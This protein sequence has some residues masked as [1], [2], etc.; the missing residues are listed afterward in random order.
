MTENS[1]KKYKDKDPA[2]LFY[3]Q[4]WLEGTREMNSEERGVYIDLLCYQHQRGSLP[5]EM[6][7]LAKLGGE[8]EEK[9]TKIWANIKSKF[10]LVNNR[11]V[12]K[13]LDHLTGKRQSKALR[14][15]INSVFALLIRYS[16]LT[17]S[18]KSAIKSKFN[19]EDFLMY[20]DEKE[21][22]QKVTEWYTQWKE[23][24]KDTNT[25]K[26]KDTN[27]SITNEGGLGEEKGK[28]ENFK[29]SVLSNR[30]WCDEVCMKTRSKFEELPIMIDN[31]ISHCIMGGETHYTEKEFKTHFRNVCLSRIEI[32]RPKADVFSKNGTI[33][34]EERVSN[35]MESL[36]PYESQY[37]KEMLEGFLVHW[38]QKSSD[39]TLLKWEMEGVFDLPNKLHLWKE[40]E[41]KFN[42]NGHGKATREGVGEAT[43][44]FKF[45]GG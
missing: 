22:S 9:F 33:S 13:K 24:I 19:F 29:K 34:I 16:D 1:S 39:G 42:K 32:V 27:T 36:S 25:T 21:I 17:F 37:G 7:R 31:F 43:R 35:F 2:F 11:Y 23:S 44:N 15:K 40:N 18:E 41:K 45:G 10:E 12:N 30:W 3:P 28:Y 8:G 38:T 5:M 4:A 20:D 14:N 26:D 6:A